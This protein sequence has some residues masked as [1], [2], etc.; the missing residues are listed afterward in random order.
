MGDD[1]TAAEVARALAD[2]KEQQR[3]DLR[4]LRETI[5][6]ALPRDVYH[7]DCRAVDERIR[8]LGRQIEALQQS[9]SSD[10]AGKKAE[11]SL[12]IAIAAVIVPAGLEIVSLWITIRGHR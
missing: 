8:N 1:A 7:A 12:R 6:G 11:R 4:D 10:E 5:N 2:H 3:D 9:K